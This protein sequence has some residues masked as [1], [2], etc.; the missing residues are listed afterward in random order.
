MSVFRKLLFPLSLVYDGITRFKNFLYNQGFLTSK[1]FNI[2]LIVIGNLSVGGTGKTP[3][4][5]YIS[6]LL[7]PVKKLAVLSR[8]YGRKTKGYVLANKNSTASE[9]G[10][11]PLQIFQ[12]IPNITVAACEDRVT[13][14]KHLINNELV[15]TIVLDD[16]FQHR[17][18]KGSFYILISTFDKPFYNDLIL[19]AGNLR[20]SKTNKNRANLIIISKCPKDLSY[21]NQQLV[22]SKIN[23]LPHQHVFFS[24]IKYDL[25]K[26]FHGSHSWNSTNNVLLVTGIV[27]PKPLKTH[28]ELSGKVVETLS[29]K[30]H[31]NYTLNDIKEITKILTSK[32]TPFIIATTSKDR[33]KIEELISNTNTDFSFFEI[34]IT[35]DFLFNQ[36]EEFNSIITNHARKI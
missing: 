21:K 5:E 29:F 15:N 13:G 30:D 2:P 25:P 11:E 16:A 7:H 12:N 6:R 10:D 35:I 28:L 4:T 1:T 22:L 34:P 14:V 18:I 20:E 9:I 8:G 33:V 19:P 36:Q 24:T 3:H 27:N 31:H 26:Q 32:K 17:K 23:P